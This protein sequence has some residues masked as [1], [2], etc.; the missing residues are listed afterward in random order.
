ML[1]DHEMEDCPTLM[2]RLCDK[3]ELQPPLTQ[4]LQMMRSEPCEEDINVNIMLR[5][6][7]TTW[8][9]KGKQ[10]EESTWVCKAPTKELEFDL[11]RTKETL[12][13]AKGSFYIASTSGSKGRLEPEMDPLMLT[14]FLDTC[15]KLLHDS[16]AIKG[17][18]EL[19]T[20]CVGTAPG[21]A[22]NANRKGN[23]ID[24][25]DQRI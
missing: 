17:L 24:H 20:R 3:G 23:E 9:D 25:T 21:E 10:P 6:G 13:E 22:H 4:N 8:D 7:F 2:V 11:E 16:K 18:Q 14:M 19:I 15:M 5:S 1:F 12:M